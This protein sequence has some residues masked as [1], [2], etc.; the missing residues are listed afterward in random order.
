MKTSR[1]IFWIPFIWLIIALIFVLIPCFK[2]GFDV[3]FK[4]LPANYQMS[5]WFAIL[6]V[7]YFL[8][9]IAIP[10]SILII[11][12][13]KINKKKLVKMDI[14]IFIIAS[15]LFIYFTWFDFFDILN[16]FID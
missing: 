14:I 3:L 5:G 15:I 16:K 11:I 10:A 13:S 4:S 6:L 7:A 8:S 12:Y 2:Y 9:L 1:L